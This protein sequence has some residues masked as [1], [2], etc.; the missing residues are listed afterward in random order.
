VSSSKV[1]EVVTDTPKETDHSITGYRIIDMEILSKV[2]AELRCPRCNADGLK[3]HE[4]FSKKAG[5]ASCL[6][7]KCS[8]EFKYNR[9]FFTSPGCQKT[10]DINYRVI[11]TM[12]TIGQK[13]ASLEKFTSF[14]NM[15][16]PM[17]NKNFNAAVKKITTIVED[18]AKNSMVDAANE[19]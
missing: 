12:R 8:C 16:R 1:K 15:P 11:Y 9:E 5:F 14:M 13:Y 3:L 2:F 4:I 6:V 18:V 7:V 19:L 10:Y 17:T